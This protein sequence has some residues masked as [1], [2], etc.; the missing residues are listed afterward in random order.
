ML[1]PGSG[2]MI[3]MQEQSLFVLRFALGPWLHPLDFPCTDLCH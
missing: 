3:E 2:G 1:M